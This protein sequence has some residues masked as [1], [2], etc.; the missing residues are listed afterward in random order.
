MAIVAR[1]LAS[2][3]ETHED[4]TIVPRLLRRSQAAQ[5]VGVSLAQLDVLRAMGEL[6]PVPMP[7]RL[8]RTIR[9]P[10]YDRFDLDAAVSRWKANGGGR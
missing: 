2:R 6:A 5:Y 10:L 8:G 3:I 1:E 7:G 4:A 9:I